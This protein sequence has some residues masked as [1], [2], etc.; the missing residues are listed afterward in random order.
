MIELSRSTI[1]TKGDH[2]V[3]YTTKRRNHHNRHQQGRTGV[4]QTVLGLSPSAVCF[5][6]AWGGAISRGR[7][8]VEQPVL[9]LL[10][11]LSAGAAPP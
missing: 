4:E 11:V 8:G 9:G 10:P 3:Y 1:I 5:T 6:V 7:T 2:N